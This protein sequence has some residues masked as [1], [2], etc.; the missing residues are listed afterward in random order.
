MEPGGENSVTQQ[1]PVLEVLGC[2]QLVLL[3]ED[4][5]GSGFGNAQGVQ[6]KRDTLKCNSD[7]DNSD[8]LLKDAELDSASCSGFAAHRSRP[9]ISA[10]AFVAGACRAPPWLFWRGEVGVEELASLEPALAGCDALVVDAVFSAP[11]LWRPYGFHHLDVV[12]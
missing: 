10:G 8:R 6:K 12:F 4:E 9:N 7:A 11:A 2:H 3:V 1:R 5:H